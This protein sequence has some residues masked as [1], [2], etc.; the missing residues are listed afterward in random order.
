MQRRLLRGVHARQSL[1]SNNSGQTKDG[2]LIAFMARPITVFEADRRSRKLK[3]GRTRHQ[4]LD[5]HEQWYRC[6]YWN[7]ESRLCTNYG[8]RPQM[9]RDFP[10]GQ[11]CGYGCDCDDGVEQTPIKQFLLRTVN[12]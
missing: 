11:P 5:S 7:E 10:Y 3:H 1:D 4:L 12:A 6:I 2:A 8:H 9:C